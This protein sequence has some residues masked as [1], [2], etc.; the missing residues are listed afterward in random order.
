MHKEIQTIFLGK[1]KDYI[2]I[3][4]KHASQIKLVLKEYL[5]N[6]KHN[7]KE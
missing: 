2:F 3:F 7:L 5:C 1:I 4:Y 6:L